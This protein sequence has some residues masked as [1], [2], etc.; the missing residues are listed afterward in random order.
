MFTTWGSVCFFCV[1][2]PMSPRTPPSSGRGQG[3][4]QTIPRVREPFFLPF[5]SLFKGNQ[6]TLCCYSIPRLLNMDCT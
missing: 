4:L 5:H 6:H 1:H 3:G 2:N